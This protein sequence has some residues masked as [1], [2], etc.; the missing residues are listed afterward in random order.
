MRKQT[1]VLSQALILSA[2]FA[3]P[4]HAAFNFPGGSPQGKPPLEHCTES[5]KTE[6]ECKAMFEKMMG[7][8]GEMREKMRERVGSGEMKKPTDVS[9]GEPR[10]FMGKNKL[11]S[12]EAKAAKLIEYLDAKNVDTTEVKSVVKTFQSKR[13]AAEPSLDALRVAQDEYRENRSEAN[14]QA[15]DTAREAVKEAMKD[16]LSYAKETMLPLFRELLS[17]LKK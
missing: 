4:V 12:L 2:A 1:I 7:S 9:K 15:L 14:K 3:L 11:I 17:S 10:A 5:G 16:S 6:E 13:A 8:S